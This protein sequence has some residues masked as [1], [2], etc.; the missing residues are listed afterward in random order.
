[1]ASPD[2]Y[3]PSYS[4]SDYEANNPRDPKPGSQ[5]D[6]QFADIATSTGSLADAI[7]DI[8][9]SDGALK[10]QI[11]T[12]DALATDTKLAFGLGETISEQIAIVAAM[13]TEIAALAG[14]E[15][16]IAGVYAV[17]ADV[18][19]VAG[20]GSHVTAVAEIAADVTAVAA[21]AA[22]VTTV[23]GID[24]DVAAV[25]GVS[26]GVATVA[27]IAID[28]STVAGVAPDVSAIASHVASMTTV[29]TGIN[30][31]AAVAANESNI[32]ALAENAANINEA[33]ANLPDLA[34]KLNKDGSNAT[35]RSK[36]RL[37]P[38]GEVF[39]VDVNAPGAEIPLI[40]A[41]C[42][43]LTAGLDGPG[44]YNEGKL[45]GETITGSGA[46]PVATA[47]IDDPD[48][49]MNGHVQNLINTEERV[50]YAGERSKSGDVFN[51]QIERIRGDLTLRHDA[52]IEADMASTNVFT[53]SSYTPDAGRVESG[54]NAARRRA[55]FDSANVV[56][57]GDRT[58]AKGQ[59]LVAFLKYKDVA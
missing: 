35:S 57:S 50:R 19:A 31:V 41:G 59:F 38:I 39:Y 17:R 34:G 10:N 55:S 47:V 43:E 25:A 5:L 54:A 23:A 7:K 49:P 30:D 27:D 51:D 37:K 2:K 22:N 45:T 36:W 16:E 11:V 3:T 28:V 6:I 58:R 18:S 29:A 52:L 26:S 53:V 46:T 40:D 42:I 24:A 4:F 20:L 21:V 44:G 15:S 8:R 9:R 14:L 13:E 32:T 33:V 48:S 56:R 1:M 12:L